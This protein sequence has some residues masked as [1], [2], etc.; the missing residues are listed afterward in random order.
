MPVRNSTLVTSY[1]GLW[2]KAEKGGGGRGNSPISIPIRSTL[3]GEN[4]MLF[5]W[6]IHF[7]HDSQ[8][9]IIFNG[10]QSL[11]EWH[12]DR[13]QFGR[14]R[15]YLC[16]TSGPLWAPALLQWNFYITTSL[17]Y[18]KYAIWFSVQIKLIFEIKKKN[19]GRENHLPQDSAKKLCGK[20]VCI[21][22]FCRKM[23][24]QSVLWSTVIIKQFATSNGRTF[25]S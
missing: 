1:W 22:C 11:S 7:H 21:L 14:W 4:L 17:T 12:G 25:L 16:S 6:P 23:S 3:S 2:R 20:G 5:C 18:T 19:N 8:I 10:L 15:R 24:R 9:A 13:P